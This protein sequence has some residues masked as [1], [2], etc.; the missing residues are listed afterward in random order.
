[1]RADPGTSTLGA[2]G[3]DLAARHGSARPVRS[4]ITPDWPYSGLILHHFVAATLASYHAKM[5]KDSEMAKSKMDLTVVKIKPKPTNLWVGVRRQRGW[6][7]ENEDA[8]PSVFLTTRDAKPRLFPF[9]L[10]K[11]GGS[12]L[13]G[14]LWWEAGNS[15]HVW[16]GVWGYTEI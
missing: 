13:K 15:A 5:D 1:M 11:A 10:G 6:R 8:H 3:Q 9:P 14:E 4:N 16:V 7:Q 12:G 2:N